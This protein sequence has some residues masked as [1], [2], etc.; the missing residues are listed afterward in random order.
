MK[1][2]FDTLAIRNAINTENN[3][4]AVESMKKRQEDFEKQ[5]K[6]KLLKNLKVLNQNNA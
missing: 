4:K 5:L 1:S 2:K 6:A 3:R